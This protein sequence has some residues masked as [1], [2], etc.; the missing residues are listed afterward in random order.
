MPRPDIEARREDA[1]RYTAKL[2]AAD[3]DYH[4]KRRAKTAA[5]KAAGLDLKKARY[6]R[7]NDK[8]SKQRAHMREKLGTK[9]R[10]APEVIRKSGHVKGPGI[11]LRIHAKPSKATLAAWKDAEMR[12]TPETKFTT[13]PSFT[14]DR[15]G[16]DL[17]AS[18]EWSKR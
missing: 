7:H 6:K 2:V 13:G 17:E 18:K 5:N 15:W 11:S 3:P 8:V 1:R 14:G 12:I 9:V 10:V 4:K 16:Q